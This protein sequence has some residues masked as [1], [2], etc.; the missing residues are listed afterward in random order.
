MMKSAQMKSEETAKNEKTENIGKKEIHRKPLSPL[1]SMQ[2]QMALQLERYYRLAWL[3]MPGNVRDSIENT[4][5]VWG[6]R[7]RHSISGFQRKEVWLDGG[8]MVYL[9]GGNPKAPPLVLLHGFAHSKDSFIQLN[10]KFQ[11]DFRII[12]PDLPGFGETQWGED[13]TYSLE[14]YGEWLT[15]FL[16]RIRLSRDF[17]LGGNSLGGAISARLALDMPRRIRSLLLLNSAGYVADEDDEF[18]QRLYN[19]ENLFEIRN[20]R[21]FEEFLDTI[22]Y[23]RPTIPFAV[24]SGLYEHMKSKAWWYH[25]VMGDLLGGIEP[26]TGDYRERVKEDALNHEI[27]NIEAETLILWGNKDNLFPLPVANGLAR[28]IPRSRLVVLPE[29][30]HCPQIE[31][32]DQFSRIYLDFL[33]S[34]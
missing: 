34:L 24:K 23:N 26:Q 12:L 33:Q 29:T 9:Q 2:K 20:W 22:F 11:R 8:K 19:G 16:D 10:R 21:G 31:K 13:E 17:H 30:G 1:A 4:L 28:D 15:E 5:S 32:P 25:K 7:A 3:Q 6:F 27:Q 14:N 18:Y